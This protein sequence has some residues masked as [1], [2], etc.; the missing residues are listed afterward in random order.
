[1]LYEINLF[2]LLSG[3]ILCFIPLFMFGNQDVKGELTGAYATSISLKY[4]I[5]NSTGTNITMNNFIDD[6]YAA[7]NK[8]HDYSFRETSML[9]LG[10]G[11]PFLLDLLWEFVALVWTGWVL[12]KKNELNDVNEKEVTRMSVLERWLFLIGVYLNAAFVFI[13]EDSNIMILESL[14]D[15]SSSA[16]VL[17][18]FGSILLF[19]SRNTVIFGDGKFVTFFIFF[20]A[21]ASSYDSVWPIWSTDSPQFHQYDTYLAYL[22][23]S[24]PLGL[25]CLMCIWCFGRFIWIKSHRKG[26]RNSIH[27]ALINDNDEEDNDFYGNIVPAW[28]MFSCFSIALIQLLWYNVGQ[29]PY[30]EAMFTWA[31]TIC[32]AIPLL[33][34]MRVRNH[35]VMNGLDQLNCKVCFVLVIVTI[36]NPSRIPLIHSL[37]NTLVHLLSNS[38]SLSHSLSHTLIN[39]LS[40][41]HRLQFLSTSQRSFVRFVSH[42]VRTP[43]STATMGLELL[44]SSLTE[45]Q[46]TTIESPTT[47]N[48]NDCHDI[49]HLIQESLHVAENIFNDMVGSQSSLFPSTPLVLLCVFV[50]LLMHVILTCMLYFFSFFSLVCRWNMIFLAMIVTSCPCPTHPFV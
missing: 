7:G 36:Q 21:A 20:F 16:S 11:I 8:E 3:T 29:T 17:L 45:A 28:H 38:L 43:L 27:Q 4:S 47:T 15:C 39:F 13:S 40:L 33:V 6:D 22:L 19:L 37:S 12:K 41:S 34:E 46:E 24:I 23:Y 31:S 25:Y 14:Y 35:E 10:L 26:H 18:T 42:E 1:M 44:S 30:Q 48:L 2:V 32:L 5:Q 49:L 50:R 9:N